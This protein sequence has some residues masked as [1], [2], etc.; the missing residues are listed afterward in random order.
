V[1]SPTTRPRCRF[2]P[3]VLDWY[4][5]SSVRFDIGIISKL[6]GHA[7]SS[8]T[9]L[10]LD[11]LAPRAVIEEMQNRKWMGAYG[12]GEY[13]RPQF[14]AD[15]LLFRTNARRSESW[16][17][18]SA[19]V[20][21][22]LWTIVAAKSLVELCEARRQSDEAAKR[23][24]PIYANPWITLDCET[25]TKTTTNPDGVFAMEWRVSVWRRDTRPFAVGP[26]N[27][28]PR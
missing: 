26:I 19:S 3:P 1:L 18:Q 27:R 28:R 2:F 9:A 13:S 23:R 4:A 20:Q 10:Y 24:T 7:S 14:V 15:Q 6:L 11:H 16:S 25:P 12:D 17:T 5:E 22:T 21:A 8:I